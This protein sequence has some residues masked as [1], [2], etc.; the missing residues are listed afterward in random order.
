MTTFPVAGASV[1][2][3]D[4]AKTTGVSGIGRAWWWVAAAAVL[5]ATL[6]L[7]SWSV[8]RPKNF[9]VVEPGRVYRSGEL[10]PSAMK[11]VVQAHGIKTV[12]DLGAYE[13]GSGEEA[14]ARQ[15]ARA[16]GVTRFVL[17]LEG[18]STGNP[19][20]YVQALRLINDPDRQPVLVHCAAGAQ[21][22]SCLILLQRHIVEGREYGTVFNEA[23]RHRHDPGNNPYVLL[24]LAQWTEKIARAYREGGLIPGVD[25]VPDPVANP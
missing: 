24:M 9:G 17:R 22:T 18:D 4:P 15:T 3:L 5:A 25:S 11:K 10:T 6:S 12:I 14:R 20:Y 1:G 7:A 8:N 21:R 13:A 2:T 16:L 19:N 23:R